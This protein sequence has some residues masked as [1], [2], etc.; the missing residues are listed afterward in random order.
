MEVGTTKYLISL[1]NG[2][3]GDSF[4]DMKIEDIKESY[5]IYGY[6]ETYGED[7]SPIDRW[8]NPGR[9]GKSDDTIDDVKVGSIHSPDG[10]DRTYE[11]YRGMTVRE[12][13]LDR[14][15]Q[16]ISASTQLKRTPVF[17]FP[18]SESRFNKDVCPEKDFRDFLK[19]KCTKYHAE[20]E[21]VKGLSKKNTKMFY[22]WYVYKVKRSDNYQ[23]HKAQKLLVKKMKRAFDI[24]HYSKFLVGA[25]PRF[26][27]NHAIL[28]V[29]K[30]MGFTN[31]LFVSYLPTV[32]DSL[33]NDVTNHVAF[34][35]WEY[36]NY[37][38][39]Q[40]RGV[41]PFNGTT[42]RV[43]SV[44]AQLLNYADDEDKLKEEFSIEEMN[45]F[46]ESLK[47]IS[48]SG[49]DMLVIDEA[50]FGGH[51]L[52]IENII[53]TVNAKAV[54][55]VTG[56]DS[57]FNED[58]RFNSEN[59]FEYSYIDECYDDDAR[60]KKMPKIRIYTYEVDKGIV[61]VAKKLFK[62]A[63]FPTFRKLFEVDNRGKF[64]NEELVRIFFEA[65]FGKRALT[66][67]NGREVLALNKVSP[68]VNEELKDRVN[69]SLVI[70][71]SVKA[72]KAAIKLLKSMEITDFDFIDA[73]GADGIG[74][75]CEVKNRIQTAKSKHMKTMTFVCRRFREG[76]TVSDWS[77]AFLFDD[78]KSFN[79]YIQTMFRVQSY[80]ENKPYCY[81][82]D[83]NPERCL[84]MRYEHIHYNREK[85]YTEE[86]M[87]TVL[88]ECMPI[89]Y[90]NQEGRLIENV[91]FQNKM[92]EAIHRTFKEGYEN[93]NSSINEWKWNLSNTDSFRTIFKNVVTS[94]SG[95]SNYI[96]GQT[97]GL[98]GGK[99]REKIR[100]IVIE[101]ENGN[102]K[103]VQREVEEL[104]NLCIETM[105]HIPEFLLVCGKKYN[106]IL[107]ALTEENSEVFNLITKVDIEDFRLLLDEGFI[108]VD[109]LNYSIH[110]FNIDK[111]EYDYANSLTNNVED[112]EGVKSIID[113]FTKKWI[114]ETG[115]E[116]D[117]PFSIL[118]KLDIKNLDGD[119]FKVCDTYCKKAH[120]LKYAKMELIKSGMTPQEASQHLYAFCPNKVAYLYAKN[121]VEIPEDN[122]FIRNE[123][124]NKTYVKWV[125]E[126]TK[127][128]SMKFDAIIQNPPYSGSLHLDF[129]E[130]G[131]DLLSEKGKMV[132]IEP[133]TWLINV[134]KNGKARRYDEIK[135]RIEGHVENVV[136]ENLNKDF[137]TENQV[138]FAT[139]TIDMSKTFN[140]IKFVC[141]G[142]EREVKSIYDCNL[143]G[144][145]ATIW[146]ILGKC[147]K[148]GDVMESH[149]ASNKD[150]KVAPQGVVFNT[151]VEGLFP[152]IGWHAKSGHN[153][154]GN[155][156]KFV[157][158][159]KGEFF[160]PFVRSL[161]DTYVGHVR[162]NGKL[163]KDNF[164]AAVYGNEKEIENWCF[165]AKSLSIFRFLTITLIIDQNDNGI[166]SFTPWLVDRQYTDEEINKLFGFTK[167]EI[168][169]IDRTI[170]KF[171]RNSPWFKRYMCGPDSVSE[172]EVNNFIKSL[173]NTNA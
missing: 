113:N 101:S 165:N 105:K 87:K 42:P 134:R 27:K 31:I 141:C 153:I 60:A 17:C 125:E 104:I 44:S 73:A 35:G 92:M 69:H 102:K 9:S 166:K 121:D 173:D 50:H 83:Y 76:V 169:L 135:K 49:V 137:G 148:F 10:S 56:T 103:V 136:V 66:I 120:T 38:D 72:V 8:E 91:E 172:V 7:E 70:L 107:D 59:V 123:R 13:V 36:I 58:T 71:P 82:F 128:K 111:E 2:S 57:N 40:Y 43:V 140:T 151:F 78:G 168:A 95:N 116:R 81:I 80:N 119:N 61:A 160:E 30:E 112:M 163:N 139:T 53:N 55:Y 145:Y 131:F 12:A 129:L 1:D 94:S 162:E 115:V 25:K 143:I 110:K 75:C 93:F 86:Q 84:K 130:K 45:D 23:M 106:N 39:K 18:I 51:T 97:N 28:Q 171:E 108:N 124:N 96:E 149:Y 126:I 114:Y 19:Y 144:N 99:I 154:I 155:D 48:S 15:Y 89:I 88:Y 152:H 167:E 62:T 79:E 47:T 85:G 142:E 21:N 100:K 157:N 132:I 32:F 122:I 118:S 65:V 11:V 34:D 29:A 46:R 24:L 74:K 161:S 3:Y 138:P 5:I 22:N 98:K 52:N 20:G 133:A 67:E 158:T 63:E 150:K 26:G 33:E 41:N 147:Q 4:L 159:K 117:V 54:V 77:A 90:H 127:A 68:F 146:S 14:A 37:R 16:D 6:I 156:A 64:R 109:E 170:K 164:K